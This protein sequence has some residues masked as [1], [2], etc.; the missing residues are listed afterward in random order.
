M[1]RG[2]TSELKECNIVAESKRYEQALGR[3]SSHQTYFREC[4]TNVGNQNY[5]TIL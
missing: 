3:F 4:Q 1:P 5:N 2:G